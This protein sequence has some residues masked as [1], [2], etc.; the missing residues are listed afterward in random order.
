MSVLLLGRGDDPVLA[1]L[2]DRA[3]TLGTPCEF[4]DAAVVA[5][6]GSWDLGL[7]GGRGE[8]RRGAKVWDLSDYATIVVR[9]VSPDP[10]QHLVAA[11]RSVEA[12][13][14][15]VA[16]HPTP[17]RCAGF[18]DSLGPWLR[19]CPLAVVNPPQPR[20]SVPASAAAR[21]AL[22]ATGLPADDW[23]WSWD[24]VPGPRMQEERTGR[25]AASVYVVGSAI[26]P[27]PASLA[28]PAPGA[29]GPPTPRALPAPAVQTALA[30]ATARLG[31]LLARW[32]ATV[33]DGGWWRWHRAD[34]APDF[35][36][37]DRLLDGAVSRTVLALR[38]RPRAKD[39]LTRTATRSPAATRPVPRRSD[40]R[41]GLDPCPCGSTSRRDTLDGLLAEAGAHLNEG[42]RVPERWC[43]PMRR[44]SLRYGTAE[45]R[46]RY[47][48][49]FNGLAQD[50]SEGTFT[51]LNVDRL[52]ALHLRAGGDGA[53]RTVHLWIPSGHTFPHPAAVL[54]LLQELCASYEEL[55]GASPTPRAS[56]ST[57]LR[58]HLRL[59]T[60]HPFRDG[61]GRLSR[62]VAARELMRSGYRSRA[63]TILDQHYERW[64]NVYTALLAA[65]EDGRICQQAC[66]LGMQLAALAR[67]WRAAPALAR[68][69]SEDAGPCLSASPQGALSE[70]AR[71]VLEDLATAAPGR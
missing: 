36:D 4:V 34:P 1:Y 35:R 37:D 10:V 26:L 21:L 51:P 47:E 20:G 16:G 3:R 52:Q 11:E 58:L 19:T 42:L 15:E 62:L 23:R 9:S 41:T 43:G 14:S 49:A 22:A 48:D 17:G 59:L 18:V 69:Q 71:P 68:T 66:L 64:P 56:Y 28:A 67:A 65:V 38:S 60:I 24:A 40:C 46:S 30:G 45:E 54:P 44:E 70:L 7:P 39:P 50:S 2:H 27:S 63:L 33:D 57:A 13:H 8:L 55:A 5:A 32:D 6:E 12:Q 25:T 29:S 31:W 53:L 61:N